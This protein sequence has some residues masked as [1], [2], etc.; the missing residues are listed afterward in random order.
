MK[1]KIIGDIRQLWR[2][3]C[4]IE[5]DLLRDDEQT[6]RVKEVLNDSRIISRED[7]N[8]F[9]LYTEVGSLQKLSNEL[10]PELKISKSTLRKEIARIRQQILQAL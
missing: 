7:R 1:P 2:L 5:P 4:D 9:I 3:S 10:A 6:L 8:L